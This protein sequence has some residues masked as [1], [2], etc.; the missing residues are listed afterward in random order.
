ALVFNVLVNLAFIP[1]F[2]FQ[3]AAAITILSEIFEGLA[4]YYYLRRSLGRMPWLR[5]LGRLWLAA[6]LMAGLTL[7]LWAWQPLVALAAG[8]AVYLAALARLGAFNAEERATLVDI[9]P[10]GLRQRLRR[11]A[12]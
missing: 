5:L 4:F 2:G 9:L 8:L 3:A 12:P 7:A 10:A 1:A 6:G 11:P